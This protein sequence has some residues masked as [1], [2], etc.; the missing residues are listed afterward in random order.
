MLRRAKKKVISRNKAYMSFFYTYIFFFFLF[1]LAYIPD[2][3]RFL[4]KTQVKFRIISEPPRI[5]L[6]GN[7]GY[8]VDDLSMSLLFGTFSNDQFFFS[9]LPVV[10]KS[11]SE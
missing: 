11:S 7:I 10:K 8:D 5:L 1:L 3:S 2:E 9:Y 6:H 4:D